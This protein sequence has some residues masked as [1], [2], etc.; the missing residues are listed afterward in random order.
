MRVDY[1][2]LILLETDIREQS[3]QSIAFKIFNS[4]KIDSFYKRNSMRLQVAK[5]RIAELMNEYCLKDENGKFKEEKQEN[6]PSEY[7]FE[8]PEKKQEYIDK[9]NYF[10]TTEFELFI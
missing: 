10:V 7:V 4:T 1:H 5:K 8:S 6:G 3:K 2:T 9:Y